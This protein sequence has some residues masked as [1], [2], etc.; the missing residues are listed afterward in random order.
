MPIH[1]FRGIN[2]LYY[3]NYRFYSTDERYTTFIQSQA[4]TDGHT[5]LLEFLPT[6]LLVTH[7]CVQEILAWLDHWLNLVHY[8]NYLPKTGSKHSLYLWLPNGMDAGMYM[9]EAC[10]LIDYTQSTIWT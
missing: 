4:V 2:I 1:E 7:L 5:Q 9:N 8:M 10:T 6:I 3:F